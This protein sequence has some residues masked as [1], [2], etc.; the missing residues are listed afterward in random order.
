M[1]STAADGREDRD[2]VAVV[3][4]GRVAVGRLVAVH[5]HARPG[6]H[7]SEVV[8]IT[9]P[10]RGEQIAELGDVELVLAAPGRLTCLR[11][12]PQANAQIGS[13]RERASYWD[14]G[15]GVPTLVRAA[16]CTSRRSGSMGL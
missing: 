13:E 1:R 9:R 12:E 15:R 8:A 10:R 5:P 11:E 7:R 6:E 2:L 16:G 4:R 3:E 14:S